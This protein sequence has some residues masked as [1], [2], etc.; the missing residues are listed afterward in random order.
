M[1]P[2]RLAAFLMRISAAVWLTTLPAG[3]QDVSPEAPRAATG[4]AQ[5]LEEIMARQNALRDGGLPGGQ[6]TLTPRETRPPVPA[7]PITGPLG[8]R[9]DVEL[10]DMWNRVRGGDPL[11]LLKP[12]PPEALMTTTGQQWRLL[13]ERLIRPYLGWLPVGVLALLAVWHLI[14]G[15]VRLKDGRSGRKVPRFTLTK[16]VAHWYMAGVFIL[17]G[18]TGLT[19]LLG[20]VLISPYLGLDVNSV[21]TSAAMQGH[22]L[23]GPLFIVAL[24]W[25]FLGYVRHNFL[26]WV[27]LKWILK[28][29]GFLGGH[30]SAGKFNFGEKTWFWMVVFFGTIIAATGI[31][32]LFPW[33]TEDV[34]LLQLAT[35]LHALSA[36]ILIA[37][38]LGHIYV[39][40]I[41]MEGSIDGM[42]TGEVDE[43]WAREHHD[44]WFEKVK[45]DEGEDT[46]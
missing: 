1:L 22:N 31:L 21:L 44:L 4:G 28:L 39:G 42:I 13:R 16:R 27:D 36:V 14:R 40:T 35:V 7:P 37:V 30:V 18:L 32:M 15:P 8:P 23:F 6:L 3:A 41:G 20:R 17:L 24:L 10:S 2:G 26:H 46:A 25:M 34:R 43:N 9:G 5:T 12:V 19:I 29:G 45:A 38:A 33:L 11:V